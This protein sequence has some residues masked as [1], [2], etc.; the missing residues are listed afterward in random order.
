[1]ELSINKHEFEKALSRV[2]GIVEKKTTMPILENVLLEALES[3]GLRVSASDLDIAAIATYKATI[4]QPGAISL[5]A[6]TLYD[7]VKQLPEEVIHLQLGKNHRTQ[8]SAGRHE[9]NV[10]GMP[11]ETYP[12]IPN[13]DDVE[14]FKIYV[15]ILDELLTKTQFAIS[16]DSTR[17]NLTGV[18]CETLENRKGLR[19]VATDGNRMSVIERETHE[20]PALTDKVIIPRKG[21]QEMRK[22]LDPTEGSVA[23][24][25]AENS[26]L[27]KSQHVM[28][29]IRLIDGRFP[30]YRQVIPPE[31]NRKLTVARTELISGLKLTA[32]LSNDRSQTVRLDLQKNLLVL[33]SEAPDTGEARAELD[34]SYD[35][36]PMRIGFNARYLLDILNVI[37]EDQVELAVTDPLAPGVLAGAGSKGFKALVMPMRAH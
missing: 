1:M 24:G 11:S 37:T 28:L 4:E 10:V 8:I 35:A 22:L 31:S 5:K 27:F 19:M 33:T 16:T 9:F 29:T 23:L 18:F 32:L 7:I 30:D 12:S 13:F 3:G 36:E 25:F 26:L 14:F 17:Y 34:V 6:K 2:Q 20:P 21:V 15:N